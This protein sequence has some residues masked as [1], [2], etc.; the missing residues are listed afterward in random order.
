MATNKHFHIKHGLTVGSGEA[1]LIAGGGTGPATREVITNTGQLVDVGALGSLTTTNKT[2]IVAAVNE[3]K[4]L[5][6]QNATIDDIIALSIAL[7]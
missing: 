2:N 4:N 1:T 7:G 5:A 3:V 6:G